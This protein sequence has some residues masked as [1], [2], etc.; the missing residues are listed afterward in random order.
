MTEHLWKRTPL[1]ESPSLSSAAG[2][3]I[4]LKLDN[5]QPSGSF[6]YRGISHLMQSAI[7]DRCP[8]SLT[9]LH[10]YCSSG[11]NAGV[12]CA[13][14]ARWMGYPATVVIPTATSPLMVKKIRDLGAIVHQVGASWAD[15]DRY[16]KENLLAHDPHGF[17]VPPFDNP[18]I[19]EGAS[20]MFE[21]VYE[22]IVDEQGFDGV[23]CSVGGGSLLTGIITAIERNF[24]PSLRRP[25]PPKV[26]A[27]ETRGAESL[28][29]SLTA[30]KHIT[31]PK[32]TS[33]A[34]SLGVVRVASRAYELAQ[35]SSV[36]S[37]VLSDAEAAMGSVRFAEDDNVLVEVSCGVALAAVY[38]GEL[39]RAM[40]SEMS[41]TEWKEMKIVVA[42]CGG[43]DVTP[44][45]LEKYKER[46]SEEVPGVMSQSIDEAIS[47]DFVGRRCSQSLGILGFDLSLSEKDGV[48]HS[49]RPYEITC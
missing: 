6:K 34:T 22:Q 49:I 45:L 14:A 37:L 41:D 3:R 18:I 7:L 4:F 17:Y 40:G 24:T 43:S 25:Q 19:W 35:K 8:E 32:I 12:A 20:S 29:A 10:Y 47:F 33:I 2:C 36:T 5:Y 13:T 23:V 39:R 9:K 28:N 48:A 44:D 15:A 11:G 31:L 16:L 26:L 38:N 42:I 46:Y 21:E 30:G 27:V 1:I